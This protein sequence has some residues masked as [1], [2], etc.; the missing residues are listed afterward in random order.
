MRPIL[1]VRVFRPLPFP[2]LLDCLRVKLFASKV[3]LLLR[4]RT[5]LTADAYNKELSI[6]TL[7]IPIV[8]ARMHTTTLEEYSTLVVRVLQ[9]VC[10]RDRTYLELL[11]CIL[12]VH[13]CECMIVPIIIILLLL[14]L[15]YLVSICTFACT[16]NAH[17]E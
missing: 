11:V 2:S 10:I 7:G 8:R 17:A 16:R 14:F 3:L 5:V 13:T 4:A 12:L 9:L 15:E 6:A 1:R